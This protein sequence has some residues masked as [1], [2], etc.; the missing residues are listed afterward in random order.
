LDRMSPQTNGL[1]TSRSTFT[2]TARAA[3]PWLAAFI[4]ALHPVCVESVAWI[5][6]QKNVLST[7]FYLWAALTYLRFDESRGRRLYFQALGLFLL[8]LLSKTVAATLPAGLLLILWWRRGKLSWQTDVLPLLPWLGVG[9]GAGL[10]SSWVERVYFGAQGGAFTLTLLQRILLAGR[11][12]WFYLGKLLWPANLIFIYPRWHIDASA[13]WQYLF[14]LAAAALAVALYILRRR[15]RGL[16]VAYLFFVGTLFPTIGFFN[17]YGFVFSYVADH[18]QYL[19]SLGVITLAAGGWGRWREAEEARTE[20]RVPGAGDRIA[21]E[22]TENLSSPGHGA[23]GGPVV[24]RLLPRLRL[25]KTGPSFPLFRFL[26]F[27]VLTTLATLTWRQCG[28]YNDMETF[29]SMT[30]AKNPACWLGYNNLG[31]LLR[32]SGRISG[33]IADFQEA[34]RLNPGL[35]DAHNNLGIALAELGR[36]PEALA[37]FQQAVKMDPGFTKAHTN[38]SNAYLMA[39]RLPEAIAEGE[40]AVREAPDYAGAQD[41]LAVALSGAGRLPEAIAHYREAVR[42][43]PDFPQAHYSL[44]VALAETGQVPDALAEFKAAIRLKP[45]YADAHYNLG[46]ILRSLGREEEGIAELQEAAR[47][48]GH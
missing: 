31:N 35:A 10:F 39:G 17:I 38:L 24:S 2:G 1:G 3:W 29:Y 13:A 32:R 9:A 33:A 19:P 11:V 36:A 15:A 44:G 23:A 43:D 22:K 4:F 42:I 21:I 47:L 27:L 18:W 37:E 48:K 25:A 5:S 45:D 16:L 28:L 41:N 6:E 8:A 46:Q 26:P 7:V 12:M 20:K 14:P 40:E 30:I 34:L